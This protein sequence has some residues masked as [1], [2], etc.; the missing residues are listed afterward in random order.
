MRYS[1]FIFGLKEQNIN[2]NRKMLSEVARFEPQSFGVRSSEIPVC[3]CPA[4]VPS[5]LP[6]LTRPSLVG[7]RCLPVWRRKG[8]KQ[9]RRGGK[10]SP[11]SEAPAD[12]RVPS[13]VLVRRP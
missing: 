12:K 5:R 7:C 10:Q 6:S 8:S 2:L 13:L 4:D 11:G 3:P 9:R 1:E